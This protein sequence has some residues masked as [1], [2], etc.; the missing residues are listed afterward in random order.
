MRL[1]QNVVQL[2]RIRK[3]YNTPAETGVRCGQ[4]RSRRNTNLKCW[5]REGFEPFP[6]RTESKSNRFSASGSSLSAAQSTVSNIVALRSFSEV[7][8]WEIQPLLPRTTGLFHIYTGINSEPL[9]RDSDYIAR[10]LV[11]SRATIL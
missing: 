10:Y 2:N 7:S 8:L 1:H 4:S 11:F 9:T 5:E 3:K 6:F